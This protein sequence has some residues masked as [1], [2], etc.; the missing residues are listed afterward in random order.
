MDIGTISFQFYSI[1]LHVQTLCNNNNEER[2]PFLV[3]QILLS[4][5]KNITTYSKNNKRNTT[6]NLKDD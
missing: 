1:V 2:A 5:L 3:F 6:F 4:F